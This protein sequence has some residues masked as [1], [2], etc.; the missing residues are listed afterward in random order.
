MFPYFITTG[1]CDLAKWGHTII[2]ENKDEGQIMQRE[3]WRNTKDRK[4]AGY[5]NAEIWTRGKHLKI[6]IIEMKVEATGID[7]IARVFR[8]YSINSRIFSKC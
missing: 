6:T 2:H 5:G 1:E 7:N 3:R 4:S 8:K